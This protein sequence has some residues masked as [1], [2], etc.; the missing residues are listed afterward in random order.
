ML[1]CLETKRLSLC[2]LTEQEA[3][4]VFAYYQR[5]RQFLRPWEYGYPEEFY[6]LEFQRQHLLQEQQAMREGRLLRLWLF[7]KAEKD[8]LRTIGTISFQPLT[9]VA[10]V[11]CRIGYK[12]D[13][14]ETGQGYMTEALQGAIEF[15]FAEY[16]ISCLEAYIMPNNQPS[17][18]I[19]EKLGFQIQGRIMDYLKINGKWEAHLQMVLQR[20]KGV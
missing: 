15:V 9:A 13:Q 4:L 8:C 20:D 11:A 16:G 17:L 18:R 6:T 14:E 7:K 1:P 12:L 2:I 5:N 19:A 3:S 10:S